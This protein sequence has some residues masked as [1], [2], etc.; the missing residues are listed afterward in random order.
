[1]CVAAGRSCLGRCDTCHSRSRPDRKCQ[2]FMPL[3]GPD[4]Y[5]YPNV[6]LT[7]SF[8]RRGCFILHCNLYLSW[9]NLTGK[10]L[11]VNLKWTW[12]LKIKIKLIYSTLNIILSNEQSLV[13]HRSLCESHFQPLGQRSRTVHRSVRILVLNLPM[14]HLDE[15]GWFFWGFSR[16]AS[17]LVITGGF[18]GDFG[19][20]WFGRDLDFASRLLW[21]GSVLRVAVVTDPARLTHRSSGGFQ[22]PRCRFFGG[23]LLEVCSGFGCCTCSRDWTDGFRTLGMLRPGVFHH[24]SL[25]ERTSRAFRRSRVS[26]VARGRRGRERGRVPVYTAEMQLANQSRHRRGILGRRGALGWDL[27][28]RRGIRLRWFLG[29]SAG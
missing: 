20:L 25:L 12:K 10:W 23:I 5:F 7:S 27:R 14:M 21:S 9:F 15:L 3:L 19:S 17:R 8:S 4:C 13:L 29:R 26:L 18:L 28:G 22:R 2:A 11:N 6:I 24:Y 1:M 16:K